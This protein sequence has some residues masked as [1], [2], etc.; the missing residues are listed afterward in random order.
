[1]TPEQFRKIEVI[2]EEAVALSRSAQAGFVRD[3]SAGDEGVR[4]KVE[5]M[6]AADST[7]YLTTPAMGAGFS[8][9][10]PD[11]IERRALDEFAAAGK[12]RIL[13]KVGE[14][15]FGA[16]FRAEQAHPVRRTV[17]LKVIKLGMD[18]RRVVARFEAERQT[19]AM[20]DHPGIAKVFEAG[21]TASGR[22]FFAMEFVEGV[23]IT[24]YC[25][26]RRL[27]VRERLAL[28]VQVCHAVR[29]AHQ[30]GVIHRDIKPSNVLVA[31][32]DARAQ[33]KVIDF[34]IARAMESSSGAS[35]AVTEQG[36]PIGTPAY[37]SPE[38]AAGRADIDTRTDI[39]SLG[40][41]LYEL[42]TGTTAITKGLLT[43]AS[44]DE[45]LR[46]V[47]EFE[48]ARPSAAARRTGGTG[49]AEARA[50]EPAS[51]VRRLS[52]DLDWITLKAMEKD[53]ARRYATVDALAA[54]IERHLRDEPV[55]AH[56]PAVIYRT[57]KF[58]RRHKAALGVALLVV[59]ALVGTS[60]GL[61][62][63]IRAE[64]RARTEAQI[65][66]EVIDFLNDDLLAAASPDE[67]GADV[68]V[69][70][71]LKQAS[72]R[73]GSRFG[74]QPEVEAAVRLTLG[75]AM[76]RLADF[77]PAHLH[78]ERALAL[79][80]S[81][82]GPDDPGT[83]AVLHEMGE[84]LLLHDGNKEAESLLRRAL[85]GRE[86]GLGVDHPDTI[87]SRY[88]L[89]V[90]LGEQERYEESA[91]QM[92]EAVERSRQV[93]GARHRRTLAMTRGIG[94]L[95]LSMGDF[96]QAEPFLRE[97]TEGLRAVIGVNNGATLLA[98]KDY[99][100]V[101]RRRG[102]LAEAKTLLNEALA[103]SRGV[104]GEQHPGTLMVMSSLGQVEHELGEIAAAEAHMS[105][106]ARTAVETLSPGHSV[107]LR[108]QLAL[109][110]F[111]QA[112]QRTNEAEAL[113][114][115]AAEAAREHLPPD[116]PFRALTAQRLA[117]HYRFV[118][119]AQAAEAWE[120]PPATE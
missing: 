67:M 60:I 106:A 13:A 82:L 92:L 64:A 115:T 85:A 117:A 38:Q 84:L 5:G 19:V 114:K 72:D 113:L 25:D 61:V 73:I 7:N 46:R 56:P 112:E 75:K 66:S 109:A 15:G 107:I 118:G 14:G 99:A 81:R 120:S 24:D 69:Q 108:V 104:R 88:A 1:M 57:R 74:D 35:A 11:E 32:H 36:L 22:P 8:V 3:R 28:F 105:L 70:E 98:M 45:V 58:L 116:S 52:G 43:G 96:V 39:Y 79:R 100:S 94:V 103:A 91:R 71:V 86:R 9:T 51:L 62:R 16:V 119:D 26:G 95:Y 49:A 34:G 33:P 101:L 90:A 80:E 40:A 65:A 110:D 37:M 10:D 68:R 89:G 97:A 53:L 47:R 18:T 12:F 20:M 4:R 21:A 48:P 78:L 27:A 30:K 17:A 31:E 2:F 44:A 63:S 111:Y 50:C 29:H 93:L 6:L 55:E 23:P 54:D 76:G 102:N 42:L 41:L 83:L 77:E 59:A 87:A